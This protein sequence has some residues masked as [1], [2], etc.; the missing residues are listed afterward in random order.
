MKYKYFMVC[1]SSMIIVFICGLISFRMLDR[2]NTNRVHF[3]SNHP[4]FSISSIIVISHLDRLNGSVNDIFEINDDDR[5]ALL[6]WF[7]PCN[8]FPKGE[9]LIKN[10]SYLIGEVVIIYNNKKSLYI[11]IPQ[12]S[13]GGFGFW[14]EN[15]YFISR[16]TKDNRAYEFDWSRMIEKC[17]KN[18]KKD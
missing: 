8:R 14:I 9:P 17:Y 15:E 11:S 7:F 10:K 6:E 18:R 1:V 4:K 13:I 12:Q 3:N 16:M 5:D 2:M